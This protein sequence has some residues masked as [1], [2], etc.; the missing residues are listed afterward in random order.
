MRP[1]VIGCTMFEAAVRE[2]ALPKRPV[3]KMIVR[4]EGESMMRA[5]MC[6]RVAERASWD[7]W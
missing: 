3:R 5:A 1:A 4:V 7:I 2:A 6:S